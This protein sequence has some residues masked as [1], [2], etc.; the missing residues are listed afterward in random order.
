MK[1][2]RENTD[3]LSRKWSKK[4]KKVREKKQRRVSKTLTSKD[5]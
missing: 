5:L 2:V 4:L 1:E 3:S